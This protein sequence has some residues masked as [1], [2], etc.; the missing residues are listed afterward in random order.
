M[1][2]ALNPRTVQVA[3]AAIGP[4]AARATQHVSGRIEPHVD[5][6]VLTLGLTYPLAMAPQLYNV[7]AL[8][9]TAGISSFTSVMGLVM[10]VA[11]T[12]YGLIHR[13][14]SIWLANGVWIAVHA[15]MIAGLLR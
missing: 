8:D 7:W 11:W 14:K 9:Q 15:A 4:R 3:A 1:A 12:L 6:M 5:R 13:Q 2:T 10:S